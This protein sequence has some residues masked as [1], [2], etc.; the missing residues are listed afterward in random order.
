[1]R[2]LFQFIFHTDLPAIVCSKV[3]EACKQHHDTVSQQ[4]ARV[5]C[6]FCFVS[7]ANEMKFASFRLTTLAQRAVCAA[8]ALKTFH[9]S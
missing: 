8:V 5:M 7:R 2:L 6:R 4:T 1:M 9:I 3:T